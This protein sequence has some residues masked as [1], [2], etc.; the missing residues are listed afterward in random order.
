MLFDSK[1]KSFKVINTPYFEIKFF[2]NKRGFLSINVW[3]TVERYNS[4]LETEHFRAF[5]EREKMKIEILW[6]DTVSKR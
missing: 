1:V 4:R 2:F 6:N 5:L 3:E